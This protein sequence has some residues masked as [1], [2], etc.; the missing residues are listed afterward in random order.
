MQGRQKVTKTKTQLFRQIVEPSLS[1]ICQYFLAWQRTIIHKM[2]ANFFMNHVSV[3]KQ[4]QL[5]NNFCRFICF[6]HH[7][8]FATAVLCA[9]FI[10][11][12]TSFCLLSCLEVRV[13]V[14]MSKLS[15]LHTMLWFNFYSTKCQPLFLHTKCQ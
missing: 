7:Q 2:C 11:I 6:A 9:N 13:V 3:P 14:Y 5:V 12:F 8:I 15:S 4:H 1:K 10:S